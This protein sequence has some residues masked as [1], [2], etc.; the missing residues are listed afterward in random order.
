ME[1]NQEDM[2]AIVEYLKT[3]PQNL[4]SFDYKDW[5]N[6]TTEKVMSIIRNTVPDGRLV[7]EIIAGAGLSTNASSA[8]PATK[9]NEF[10][11]EASSTN[12][13][14]T[15]TK[16]QPNTSSTPTPASSLDDLYAD[17]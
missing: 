2:D 8:A 6:E 16:A 1:K 7:N 11:A 17:L 10:F 5:D 14:S 12:V 9:S 3:G 15:S 4:A 13:G